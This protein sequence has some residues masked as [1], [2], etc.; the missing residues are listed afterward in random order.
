MALIYPALPIRGI[1]CARRPT[2]V[3]LSGSLPENR[4]YDRHGLAASA[5]GG[6]KTGSPSANLHPQPDYALAN[7]DHG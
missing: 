6:F 4:C 5:T 3:D 2:A 7:R 1:H